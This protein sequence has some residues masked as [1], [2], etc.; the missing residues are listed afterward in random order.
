MVNTTGIA[1]FIHKEM[2]KP[3]LHTGFFVNVPSLPLSFP[4]GFSLGNTFGHPQQCINFHGW[5]RASDVLEGTTELMKRLKVCTCQRGWRPWDTTI[6]PK[7]LHPPS[8]LSSNL[9]HEP[10][11]NSAFE[12]KKNHIFVSHLMHSKGNENADEWGFNLCR[13]KTMKTPAM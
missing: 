2:P 3:P 13:K 10:F 5:K 1:Y 12:K 9:W 6:S 7:S 11:M 4:L 8:W